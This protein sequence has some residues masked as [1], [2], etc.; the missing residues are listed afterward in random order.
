MR[1]PF[2]QK[3]GKAFIQAIFLIG[4]IF[5][6]LTMAF[7][8]IYEKIWL[9]LPM[10][11]HKIKTTCGC[12]QMASLASHPYLF[13]ALG[14]L[15]IFATSFLGFALYTLVSLMIRTR[16]YSIDY[17]KLS[18]T[19]HS[20]KLKRSLD[21]LGIAP[22]RVVEIRSKEPIVFCFGIVRSKICIANGLT[23]ILEYA[24]LSAVLLHER[25]HL[26][27]HDPLRLFVLKYFQRVLF[28]V[29]G[30]KTIIKKYITFSEL[31]ADE[32]A[33]NN[34]LNK[35]I[36]ARAIFKVAQREEKN[37]IRAG[38]A[39]SFFS[40]VIDERVNRLS[41]DNYIPRFGLFGR[42]FLLG[43]SSII[44][45]S[46]LLFVF[47]TDTS[48]AFGSYENSCI[49]SELTQLSGTMCKVDSYYQRCSMR[50]VAYK[51]VD[52]CQLP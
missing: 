18:K 17:L 48:K 45:A 25:H 36:L 10:I 21:S 43:M 51:S 6:L 50:H 30:I 47:L 28:F 26:I 41:D 9:Y 24:E 33:T 1:S 37:I 14:A 8:K 19:T 13:A 35:S 22:G 44:I 32:L 38:L 4:I 7:F 34:F 46:L 29:P 39:L 31:A 52:S 5:G 23:D 49:S 42:G 2:A 27:S 11:T 40:S 16:K 15:G 20:S 12:S 3:T